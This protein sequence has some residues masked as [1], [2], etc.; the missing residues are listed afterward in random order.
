MAMADTGKV[1]TPELDR[2]SGV[3]ADMATIADFMHWAES[4]RHICTSS[5]CVGIGKGVDKLL[6]E[7]FGLDEKKIEEER[8]AILETINLPEGEW[9]GKT[10][11]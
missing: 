9:V 11:E 10:T 4:K 7:Y 1:E 5:Q 2:L 6:V 8:R 3:K